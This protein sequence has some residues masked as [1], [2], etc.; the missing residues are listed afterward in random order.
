M[1]REQVIKLKELLESK[2]YVNQHSSWDREDASRLC[3]KVLGSF[4]D[5]YHME[6]VIS[7][8]DV[9]QISIASKVRIVHANRSSNMNFFFMDTSEKNK[10]E[11]A[12][13]YPIMEFDLYFLGT[14]ANE[15]EL[16]KVMQQVGCPLE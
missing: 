9:W 14:I 13:K 15:E 8:Q 6:K 7:E 3:I 12:K 1:E 5:S 4:F 11:E 2:G 16:I 10:L